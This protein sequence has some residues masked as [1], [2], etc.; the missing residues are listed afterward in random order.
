MKNFNGPDFMYRVTWRRVVGSGP[1]WHKENTTEPPLMVRDVGDFSAFEI[2]VQAINA[3]G[4]G[5]EPDPVI[6]Y[7]GEDGEIYKYIPTQD[8]SAFLSSAL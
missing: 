8:F 2:K 1:D 7:S 4:E 5:P 3:I 6:G